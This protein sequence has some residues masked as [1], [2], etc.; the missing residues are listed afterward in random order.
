MDYI[1]QYNFKITK[2]LSQILEIAA[3]FR[4]LCCFKNK[5]YSGISRGIFFTFIYL[6]HVSKFTFQ[7]FFKM[8]HCGKRHIYIYFWRLFS[9]RN[10][11][12]VFLQYF[13]KSWNI[14]N[15]LLF[16]LCFEAKPKLFSMN[17][18]CFSEKD[19]QNIRME[20]FIS[21]I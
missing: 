21:K 20:I 8:L 4:K 14:W 12:H 18:K 17:H 19:Y 11:L 6:F 10:I 7:D 5:K 1:P 13:K 3:V 16:D 15:E 2:H 9:G